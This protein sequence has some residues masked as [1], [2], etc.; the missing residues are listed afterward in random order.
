M[1]AVPS[2]RKLINVKIHCS[3]T[4]ILQ[5]SICTPHPWNCGVTYVATRQ[6]RRKRSAGLG[7]VGFKV[8]DVLSFLK[9]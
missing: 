9:T 6:L 2:W 1:A 8:L 7:K 5:N 4:W 3:D